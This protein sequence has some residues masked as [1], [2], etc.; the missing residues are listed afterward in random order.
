MDDLELQPKY[1]TKEIPGK[2]IKCLAEQESREC[3]LELLRCEGEN[4]EVSKIYEALLS[5]LTSPEL[6]RLRD[7]TERHLSEGRNVKVILHLSGD[8]P[9]YE[10]KVV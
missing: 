7:E 10:I 3:L 9:R 6:Y 2:C 8:K 1:S 5:L 4:K